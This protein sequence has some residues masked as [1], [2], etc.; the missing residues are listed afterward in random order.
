M[1]LDLNFFLFVIRGTNSRQVVTK[2]KWI[3]F[4]AI[5]LWEE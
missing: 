3:A 1:Y 2:I 5:I 4:R